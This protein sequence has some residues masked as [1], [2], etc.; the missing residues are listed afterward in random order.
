VPAVPVALV[1]LAFA[2]CAALITFGGV[3]LS[4]YGHVIAERTGLG[5]SWVGIILLA[6]VTSLPELVTGISA[7]SFANA[8]NIAVGDALG[9]CVFNL[10]IVSVLDWLHREE[11]LFDRADIG[12]LLSAA[13]G[14]M[15]LGFV[16]FNLV[17]TSG[18]GAWSIG[19]VGLYTPV[20]I[21]F[22]VLSMWIVFSYQKRGMAKLTEEAAREEGAMTL[23]QA[24]RRYAA[25][26]TLVLAA[27]TALPFAGQALAAAYGWNTSFVGTLLVAFATSLP[28]LVV[29]VAALR[30]GAIDM[31]ISNLLGSNLFDVLII[32]IDD[33]FYLPGPI[34][35]HVSPVHAA[36]TL[37][38]IVMTGAFVAGLV[39][40]TKSRI[41]GTVGWASI[42][43]LVAYVLNS[44]FLF[45]R[46]A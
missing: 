5:G 23:A 13:F 3:W 25:A 20:I 22:Y 6:T 8:P 31:A 26:A 1:W 38:A 15:L 43:L 39:F 30:L 40:R 18:P 12:H 21:A 10:A 37:S 9:S 41:F 34:L 29:T 17:L 33:L 35:S 11:S 19:H 42:F 28:E 36:S 46:G 7:V 14:I 45:L 2:A 16:A 32:A 27:G 4:R 44:Y 24:A